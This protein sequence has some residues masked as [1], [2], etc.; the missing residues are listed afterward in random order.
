MKERLSY[1]CIGWVRIAEGICGVLT[2]GFWLPVWALP[3]TKFFAARIMK[4]RARA[5]LKLS[6]M[7]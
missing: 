1:W 5:Q 3:V 2:L 6:E 4:A 7:E